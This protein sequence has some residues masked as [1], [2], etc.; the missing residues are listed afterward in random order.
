MS[1]S[2]SNVEQ[3]TYCTIVFYSMS[4]TKEIFTTPLYT[5]IHAIILDACYAAAVRPSIAY[6]IADSVSANIVRLISEKGP[7]HNP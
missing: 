2:G 1:L 3:L 4:K 6:R 7:L 5:A